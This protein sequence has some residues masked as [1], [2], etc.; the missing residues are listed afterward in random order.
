MASAAV[1]LLFQEL[2]ERRGG[3]QAPVQDVVME[4]MLIERQSTAAV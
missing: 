4:H 1:G 3:R 2:R